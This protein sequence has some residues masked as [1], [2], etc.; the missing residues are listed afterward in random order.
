MKISG[1]NLVKL[2]IAVFLFGFAGLFGKFLKI[3]AGLIVWGRVFFASLTML[4]F[5]MLTRKFSFIKRKKDFIALILSGFLLLFHWWTFFYAV[6]ISSVAI[7]LISFSMYP[8]F[9]KLFD[10]VIDKKPLSF[11]EILSSVLMLI[12]ILTMFVPGT[13]KFTLTGFAIGLI[14]GL[15]F[16]LLT[17][18]NK[19]FV[20]VYSA[21]SITMYQMVF[22]SI[23]LTFY[24]NVELLNLRASEYLQLLCLGLFCTA[25]AHTLF[26]MS[27]KTCSAFIAGISTI[28]E[29]VYG[30]ILAF[31][32]LDESLTLN[33]IIGSIIIFSSVFVLI[34]T[35]NV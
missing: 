32:I 23:I 35:T 6:R 11:A 18:V 22:I 20:T 8:L 12:G 17:L 3:D 4:I 1:Y 26:I 13:E 31:F 5:F 7:A 21:E 30:I 9:I 24:Y 29:P 10:I 16:G 14:S 27:L 19:K 2:N 34:K 33:Q 25:L 28:L 15:S